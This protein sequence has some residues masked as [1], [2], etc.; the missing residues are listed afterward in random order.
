MVG[1][2]GQLRI[3]LGIGQKNAMK[4]STEILLNNPAQ[5]IEGNT[6]VPLRFI[7][8]STGANVIWDGTTKTV[9]IVSQVKNKK[10]ENNT[11][12]DNPFTQELLLKTINET[13]EAEHIKDFRTQPN[14]RRN[15][16]GKI[17]GKYFDLYYPLDEQGKA[18]ADFLA[19]YMDT[20]YIFLTEIYGQQAPVEVHLIHEKDAQ[21][22][23]EGDIR[24]REKVTFV[25]IEPNNVQGGNN[26]AELVH[27]MNHNFFSCVFGLLSC[28]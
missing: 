11:S 20:A 1:I 23:R 25:W 27:E 7:A 17:E 22:L 18:V 2:K 13:P 6:Y 28:A 21:S 3:E 24:Q 14:S 10:L 12:S 26:I 16:M 4:N 8:E 5:V 19:P 15:G 9:N